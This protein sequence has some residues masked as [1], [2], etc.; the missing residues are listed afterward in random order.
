LHKDAAGTLDAADV[1]AWHALFMA[2]KSTN[3]EAAPQDSGVSG[4]PGHLSRDSGSNV[5]S[6]KAERASAEADL[7]WPDTTSFS[8]ARRRREILQAK[9]LQV[10]YDLASGAVVRIADVAS[11]LGEQCARIRTKLLSIPSSVSARVALLND[12]RDVNDLLASAITDALTEL[13]CDQAP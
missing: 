9:K 13:T 4:D 8:E 10:E 3:P 11:L 7:Q 2:G 12:P 1:A 5:G 6:T